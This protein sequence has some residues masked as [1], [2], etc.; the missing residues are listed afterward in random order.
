MIL[1]LLILGLLGW[2]F[3]WA[4]GTF[5]G[6]IMFLVSLKHDKQHAKWLESHPEEG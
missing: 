3:I 6:F 5:I 4:V 2:I 1:I